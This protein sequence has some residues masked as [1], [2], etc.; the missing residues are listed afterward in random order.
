LSI[1]SFNQET[2]ELETP[3]ISPAAS[4]PAEPNSEASQEKKKNNFYYENC[5]SSKICVF[6][7]KE[8]RTGIYD[9]LYPV[10]KLVNGDTFYYVMKEG[11]WGIM[12]NYG[13]LI[14]PP[15]HES[16]GDAL[17]SLSPFLQ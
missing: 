12:D 16:P 14:I 10:E 17:K 6:D 4:K 9:Y 2:L 13:R 3:S 15:S 5:F 1:S 8:K 11:S 7:S